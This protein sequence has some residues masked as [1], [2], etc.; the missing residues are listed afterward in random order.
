MSVSV[1][2]PSLVHT[3]Y[4]VGWQTRNITF[5]LRILQGCSGTLFTP[6]GSYIPPKMLFPS[7]QVGVHKGLSTQ[8]LYN[9]PV[10]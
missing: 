9:I 8:D 1:G 5:C 4:N 7:F 3:P 6:C 10:P 2:G